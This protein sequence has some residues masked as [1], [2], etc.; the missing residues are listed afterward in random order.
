MVK[1]EGPDPFDVDMSVPWTFAYYHSFLIY[2]NAPGCVTRSLGI[3]PTEP[4]E[5]GNPRWG[6]DVER[7]RSPQLRWE[8]TSTKRRGVSVEEMGESYDAELV[9]FLRPFHERRELIRS[10]PNSCRVVLT[11]YYETNHLSPSPGLSREVI[12]MLSDLEGEYWMSPFITPSYFG[13]E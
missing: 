9:A 13:F 12:C 8:L 7:G 4:Y 10:L 5:P 1:N 3:T 6:R 11:T 2:D